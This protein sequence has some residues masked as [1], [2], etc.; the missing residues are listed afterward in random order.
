MAH[1]RLTQYNQ[2]DPAEM[3]AHSIMLSIV[4]TFNFS[5]ASSTT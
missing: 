4:F 3:N 1:F 5:N 2:D